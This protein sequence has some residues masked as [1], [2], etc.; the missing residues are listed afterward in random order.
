M[1]TGITSNITTN[2]NSNSPLYEMH[3]E[4]PATDIQS[5][6]VASFT[7]Y[8][9]SLAVINGDILGT[10]DTNKLKLQPGVYSIKGIASDY[11]TRLSYIQI[12]DTTAVGVIE[13]SSG[14]VYS[15]ADFSPDSATANLI[16]STRKFTLSVE[17]ELEFRVF[18]E[19]LNNRVENEPEFGYSVWTGNTA[20]FKI[21]QHS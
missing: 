15:E 18:G 4:I 11:R 14:T 6:G 1:A 16:V 8:P 19:L 17:S 10:I 21:T 13:D 12:Y 2:I 7:T 9:L 5:V 20:Q 3:L